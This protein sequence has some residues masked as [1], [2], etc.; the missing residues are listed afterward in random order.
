MDLMYN[1]IFYLIIQVDKLLLLL[2]YIIIC[3]ILINIIIDN[4]IT[5]I[6]RVC[7]ALLVCFSYPLQSHPA[8][9][10][11]LSLISLVMGDEEKIKNGETISDTVTNFR[12]IIVTVSL[13][14]KYYKYI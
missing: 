7:V 12:Y 4:E 10:S 1:L 11:I 5:S 3:N 6:A 14:Y 9:R 2:L 8:R 13:L